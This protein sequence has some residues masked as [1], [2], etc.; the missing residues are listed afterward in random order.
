MKI[1]ATE[2]L[3][4]ACKEHMI[5]WDLQSFQKSHFRLYRSILS[6]MKKMIDIFVESENVK[7]KFRDAPIGARFKHP[8]NNRI[9]VK[10]NSYP[11]GPFHDGNGLICSWNGNNKNCH[12][13]FHAFFDKENGID[14][15]T[16]IELI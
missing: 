10:I 8:T 1:D 13:N 14:F 3:D 6:A 15:D 9:Y 2:I 5:K 12:P 16:E 11:E 4:D 7:M